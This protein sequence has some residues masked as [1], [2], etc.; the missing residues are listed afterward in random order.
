MRADGKPLLPSEW[1][2][3][4]L[5]CVYLDAVHTS[6]CVLSLKFKVWHYCV[7]PGVCVI[8]VCRSSRCAA[9][10]CTGGC[11]EG[12]TQGGGGNQHCGDKPHDTGWCWCV[13][14]R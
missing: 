3:L 11:P 13:V 9:A 1:W 6:D 10:G 2:Q 12:F 4:H 14:T 5:V 7:D 8:S